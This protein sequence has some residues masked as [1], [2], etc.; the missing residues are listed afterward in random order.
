MSTRYRPL[1]SRTVAVPLERIPLIARLSPAPPRVVRRTPAGPPVGRVL[2]SYVRQP[3]AWGPKDPRFAG[4]TNKW[5]SYAIARSLLKQG[6]TVDA[7]E[8]DD[9]SFQPRGRYDVVLA[10]DAELVRLSEAT[11]TERRLLHMTVSHPDFQDAAEAERLDELEWRRGARLAPRRRAPDRDAFVEAVHAATGRSLIGN[12]Q[13]LE[14]YPERFDRPITCLAVTA[15]LPSPLKTERQIAHNRGEFLWFFGGGAVHKGLDRVLEAFATTPALQ[16]N[17]IGNI[18]AEEDFVQEYRRELT[19]L[20]NI[21]WHG[22]LEPA[23][24]SFA[25]IARHCGA[26]IAPSCSEGMSPATA[27]MLR[28][29]LF[30]VISRHT[31]ID[32]PPD[33]GQYLET[34]SVDEIAAAATSVAEMDA[35]E[36]TRQTLQTQSRAVEVHSRERFSQAIERYLASVLRR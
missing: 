21:R 30:P 2:M 27:T 7:I 29:G 34:C 33:C 10:N 28:V 35:D 13:T 17:V 31:G 20:P 26:V 4:H 23:S 16:L 24:R 25:R 8:Y 5:E 3:I 18:G 14:T 36:R 22:Y 6:F 11:G 9:R 12:R 15:S 19:Q 32:L 1:A